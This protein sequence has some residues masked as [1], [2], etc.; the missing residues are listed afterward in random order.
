MAQSIRNICRLKCLSVDGVAVTFD[1]LSSDRRVWVRNSEVWDDYLLQNVQV[2]PG[3]HIQSVKSS[4][5][6]S[7]AEGYDVTNFCL[8]MGQLC[9]HLEILD[10]K[11]DV[12]TFSVA[13]KTVVWA[14]KFSVRLRQEYSRTIN[15]TPQYGLF[16]ISISPHDRHHHYNHHKPFKE[17]GH[18]L[19]R[20]SLISTIASSLVSEF[21]ILAY[22]FGFRFVYFRHVKS[23]I[24]CIIACRLVAK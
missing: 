14:G 12:F 20:S 9:V 3:T 13:K 8:Y 10:G 15:S 18:L 23:Y 6:P 1:W 4:W 22:S 7:L 5:P 21:A 17:S 19:A 11:S 16:I 2:G 24:P